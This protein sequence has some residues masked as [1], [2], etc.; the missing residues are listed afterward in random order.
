MK[1]GTRS[2]LHLQLGQE[3]IYLI[4]A[5]AVFAAMIL[6]SRQSTIEREPPIILMREADGYSFDTGSAALSPDFQR[7]LAE[8][9]IP[10]VSEIG[11][12]FHATVIEVIGHTDEV[13][14]KQSRRH[15]ANL[16]QTLGEYLK[17]GTGEPI[18]ADNVGLGMARAVA[19][20]RVLRQSPLAQR[21]EIIPISAGA[22]QRPDDT[23]GG[24]GS[25]AVSEK[26]RRRIEIRVRRKTVR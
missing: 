15:V 1:S 22:F 24:L 8:Q 12:T 10:Q 6:F 17:D 21:F 11:D 18:A 4:M 7:K 13:P 14:L 23:A 3:I 25:G 16:D 19:V 5:I 2:T 9:V 26:D 20:A